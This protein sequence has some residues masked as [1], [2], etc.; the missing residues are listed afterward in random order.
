MLEIPPEL[1]SLLQKDEV[2]KRFFDALPPSHQI[3]YIR[4][5]QEAKKAKTRL[6]RAQQT[7][8]M[9]NQKT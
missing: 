9:L 5:I 3:E 7:I 1:N 4:W 2:A 6:N 8:V